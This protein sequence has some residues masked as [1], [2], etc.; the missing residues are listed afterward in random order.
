[1]TL[2]QRRLKDGGSIFV[3]AKTCYFGVGGGTRQFE[4]ALKEEGLSS[5][6]VWKTDNGIQREIIKI[7]K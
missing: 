3:A 2:F 4:I 5:Q 1:M 7:N 6:V